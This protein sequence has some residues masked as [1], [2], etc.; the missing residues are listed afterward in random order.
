MTIGARIKA[1]SVIARPL[2]SCHSKSAAAARKML[3][4]RSSSTAAG[5][6]AVEGLDARASNT[7]TTDRAA[8]SGQLKQRAHLV[9]DHDREGRYL[10]AA[11]QQRHDE[12]P[13]VEA[14]D[15]DRARRYARPGKRQD[16]VPVC[17]DAVGTQ[18]VRRFFKRYRNGPERGR[19]RQHGQGNRGLDEAE[20]HAGTVEQQ[21]E[22]P[23]DAGQ[24][25]PPPD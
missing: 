22:R 14:E 4:H 25:Q 13:R 23:L 5:D 24:P 1:M 12:S 16:D 15:Q 3:A 8:P 7:R 17:P 18:H 21:R 9:A 11:Q 2:I 10:E 6:Q 19:D 20:Q